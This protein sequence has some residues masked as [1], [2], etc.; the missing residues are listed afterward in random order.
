MALAIKEISKDFSNTEMFLVDMWPSYP[1]SIVV[2][3][4]EAANLIT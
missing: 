4:P 2:F 3:N 1:A